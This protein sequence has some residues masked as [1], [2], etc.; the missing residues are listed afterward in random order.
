MHV[1]N[2][3]QSVMVC[4]NGYMLQTKMEE[5]R[6]FNIRSYWVLFCKLTMLTNIILLGDVFS[7]VL[8]ETQKL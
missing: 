3:K 2:S 6:L 1:V 8:I 4:C 5:N 7:F